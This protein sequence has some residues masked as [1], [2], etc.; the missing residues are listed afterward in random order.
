MT[1]SF[2]SKSVNQKCIVVPV[3]HTS[4]N[5]KLSKDWHE[6]YV[7][8]QW[9]DQHD[10]TWQKR[11]ECFV[12]L[13]FLCLVELGNVDGRRMVS[14]LHHLAQLAKPSVSFLIIILIQ[15]L[16]IT[17]SSHHQETTSR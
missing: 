8:N 5:M 17:I 11:V 16:V 12:E 7:G 10:V 6:I 3:V 2:R 1:P 14:A 15:I 13:G 9:T 4:L